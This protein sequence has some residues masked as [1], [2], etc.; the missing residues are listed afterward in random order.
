MLKNYRVRVN[1][2]FFDTMLA[3]YLIEPDMR[4]NMDV[5]AETYLHYTPVPITD[6]IG[7]KGKNQK[8]MADLRP[9]RR[10]RLR[11]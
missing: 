4:H 10:Q 3:H 1:G 9:G 5:L 8:T 6:L 2:P 7:P 11:L